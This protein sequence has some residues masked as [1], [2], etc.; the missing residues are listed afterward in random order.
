MKISKIA[1]AILPLAAMLVLSGCGTAASPGGASNAGAA[2]A[3]PTKTDVYLTIATGDM[4]S[5]SGWP[6]FLPANFTLPAHA[7]V[8]VHIIN[9]DG[10]DDMSQLSMYAKVTGTV[11]NTVTVQDMSSDDPNNLGSPTTSSALDVAS[12]VSHTFTI[13]QLDVNVPIAPQAVTTFTIKTGDAG[14]Y[15]WQCMVP[16]G[17]DPNGNGGAMITPD[18]MKGTLTIA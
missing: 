12:G 8:T 4:I 5:K 13:P 18:F 2:Q 6:V 17:T 15:T 10:A 7:T 14:T 16:C 9:F 11:D 3:N 1:L